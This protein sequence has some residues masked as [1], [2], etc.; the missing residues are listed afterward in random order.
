M[1]EITADF[2]G[3]KLGDSYSAN[4]MSQFINGHNLTTTFALS[5]ILVISRRDAQLSNRPAAVA[6]YY[7]KLVASAFGNYRDLSF[8][9]TM[10]TNRASYGKGTRRSTIKDSGSIALAVPCSFI[11]LVQGV[12]K[13]V[14]LDQIRLC[15]R[16]MI[17]NA[18]RPVNLP[19]EAT[20]TG[21]CILSW[22]I[23]CTVG[24]GDE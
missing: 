15:G 17:C 19:R 7:D 2:F 9:V 21:C 3:P 10:Q 4:E 23:G 20:Q 8:E 13:F 22:L 1:E 18:C 5:Q 14:L 24:G 16:Q 12:S 11:R 6:D